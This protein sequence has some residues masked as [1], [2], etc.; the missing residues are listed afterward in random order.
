MSKKW[1]TAEEVESNDR[2]IGDVMRY[3]SQFAAL[4]RQ[5][6]AHGSPRTDAR[7]KLTNLG[8][9]DWE[10][11]DADLCRHFES[12]LG[13]VEAR[14]VERFIKFLP[15]VSK[16]SSAL[17]FIAEYG[18]NNTPQSK[19]EL[20][21]TAVELKELECALLPR[22]GGSTERRIRGER[23]TMTIASWQGTLRSGKDRRQS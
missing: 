10:I 13:A 11:V 4:L 6:E 9:G 17:R 20:H 23:R 21:K 5:M 16:A 15:C 7:A 12:A 2:T 1:P 8:D 22:A 18:S 3:L 14:T 19:E